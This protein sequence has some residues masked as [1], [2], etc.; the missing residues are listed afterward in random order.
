M[1]CTVSGRL[2]GTGQK[3]PISTNPSWVCY[4]RDCNLDSWPFCCL[5]KL[6]THVTKQY[7][8]LPVA[9]QRCPATGR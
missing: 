9:Q 2:F 3:Q 1:F 7:D 6:F 4:L 8:L 5:G